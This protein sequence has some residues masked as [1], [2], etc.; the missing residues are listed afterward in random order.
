MKDSGLCY[1]RR[2][3]ETGTHPCLGLWARNPL[4]VLI[5]CSMTDLFK[6]QG[7]EYTVMITRTLSSEPRYDTHGKEYRSSS[8]NYIHCRENLKG[9]GTTLTQS[10]S[11]V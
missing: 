8:E 7:G 1:R 10:V 9:K 6:L 11:V 4:F 3:S 5:T 2:R